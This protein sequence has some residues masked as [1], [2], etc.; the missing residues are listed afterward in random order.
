MT[1]LNFF[2]C[3]LIN[4]W[5]FQVFKFSSL[6]IMKSSMVIHPVPIW[7]STCIIFDSKCITI[8]DLG[9]NSYSPKKIKNPIQFPIYCHKANEVLTRPVHCFHDYICITFIL[10]LS[11]L[12]TLCVLLLI[13][14]DHLQFCCTESW[15]F[16]IQM[17]F[18][19]FSFFKKRTTWGMQ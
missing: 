11:D 14:H 5:L 18:Q 17:F 9:P 2:S 4:F 6:Q 16:I 13:T 3:Q 8:G 1:L 12:S 19:H 10:I 15:I 7:L